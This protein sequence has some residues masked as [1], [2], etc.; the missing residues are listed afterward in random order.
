MENLISY[1]S[2]YV[3]LTVCFLVAIALP[4]TI[5]PAG[6]YHVLHDIVR[7]AVFAALITLTILALCCRVT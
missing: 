4:V 1:L 6:A 3:S 7:P 2:V 5:N